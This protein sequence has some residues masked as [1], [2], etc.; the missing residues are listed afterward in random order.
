[1]YKEYRFFKCISVMASITPFQLT[2]AVSAPT[3]PPCP[4][5]SSRY[6]LFF[7]FP[8]LGPLGSMSA[9]PNTQNRYGSGPSAPPST[10]SLL[11]APLQDSPSVP[12]KTG[13][14]QPVFSKPPPSIR[15]V[16]S[17]GSLVRTKLSTITCS[18]DAGYRGARATHLGPAQA[19]L[20]SHRLLRLFQIK[21]A[22]RFD[23]AW[24][25]G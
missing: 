25:L 3:P 19:G 18:T 12:S 5:T 14:L 11:N 23:W 4:H 24:L 17:M 10:T 15:S 20:G 1:M 2:V 22:Y 8:W 9:F 21:S 16:A 6:I 13:N 7:S